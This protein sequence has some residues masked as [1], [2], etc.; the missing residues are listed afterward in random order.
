MRKRFII[1]DDFYDDPEKI[2]NFARTRKFEENIKYYKGVRSTTRYLPTSTKQKIEQALNLFIPNSNWY[3]GL[4]GCFQIT[5]PKDPT[6]Y[7]HDLQ[8]WAGILYLDKNAPINSG[9]KTYINIEDGAIDRFSATKTTYRHG[10]LDPSLFKEVDSIGNIFNRLVLMDGAL[11][12]SAGQYY[13]S[14]LENGRL[15]QL[16]FFDT[17]DNR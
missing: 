11:I 8:D 5:L 6:V 14:S 10:H 2:A 3:T 13:G 1:L 16:F 4:N 12:H 7:H 9:T 17:K 15:V